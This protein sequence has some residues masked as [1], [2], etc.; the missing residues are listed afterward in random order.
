MKLL[1]ALP[2]VVLQNYLILSIP[3]D[4]PPFVGHRRID[5]WNY[6]WAMLV[7]LSHVNINLMTAC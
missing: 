7:Q 3:T 2:N 5:P 6:T 4:H 1:F